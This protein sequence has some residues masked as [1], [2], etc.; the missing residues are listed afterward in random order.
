METNKRIYSQCLKQVSVALINIISYHQIS[1]ARKRNSA[2]RR[3][4]RR[5][6]VYYTLLCYVQLFLGN[7]SEVFLFFD[8]WFPMV[9]GNES[10]FAATGEKDYVLREGCL[11][12][13]SSWDNV[14]SISKSFQ[15]FQRKVLYKLSQILDTIQNIC[16]DFNEAP[17][18][19]Q[20]PTME[21]FNIAEQ[22]IRASESTKKN[23]VSLLLVVPCCK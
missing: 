17:D 21:D 5:F 16:Q 9:Q 1:N 10:V 20:V 12:C 22:E 15:G 18:F 13:L 4:R 19:P 8:Q 3:V 2:C 14:L 6:K 7:S 11:Y 23:L